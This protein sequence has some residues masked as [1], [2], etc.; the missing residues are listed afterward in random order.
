MAAPRHCPRSGLSF[1][2]PGF[3]ATARVGAA[4]ATLLLAAC[5]S[6]GGL[7]PAGNPIDADTLATARSL[8]AHAPSDAAFPAADCWT[9][10]GDPQLD[11]LLREAVQDIPSLA[12]PDAR[13]RQAKAQAGLADA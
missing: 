12:A 4:A 1:V 2:F 10:L 11:I 13:V 5:A 8:D 6:T 9:A 7:A 3:A